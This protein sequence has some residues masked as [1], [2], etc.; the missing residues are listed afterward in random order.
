MRTI[1]GDCIDVALKKR[2]VIIP[3][4]TNDIGAWGSG[5][6]LALSK[7]WPMSL[8]DRSPEFEY[9]RDPRARS[10]GITQLVKSESS[11][12][13]ALLYVANMCSQKGIS[14]K[15]VHSST[16]RNEKPIKYVSLMTCMQTVAEFAKEKNLGIVCPKF[17]SDR[18]GG[19]WDFITELIE[20]IWDG[21]DVTVC[22]LPVYKKGTK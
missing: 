18:A 2:N 17:G 4:V 8:R 14:S 7:K 20:E 12:E 1:N 3:H 19:N 21:I 22:C 10:L 6:V 13:N 16:E 11:G 15:S 9:K 5:F